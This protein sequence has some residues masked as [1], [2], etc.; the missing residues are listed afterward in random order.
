MEKIRKIF[1]ITCIFLAVIAAGLFTSGFVK[2]TTIKQEIVSQLNEYLK[3]EISVEDIQFQMLQSFPYATISFQNVSTKGV[4]PEAREKLMNAEEVSVLFDIMELIKGN[5]TLKKIKIKNAFLNILVLPDGTAN[6]NIISVDKKA[7]SSNFKIDLKNVEFSNVSI[8]YVH[9]PSNQEYLFRINKGQL[10]GLFSSENQ[11]LDFDG[12]IFS[13]HIKSGSKIF[14]E[15][16]ELTID[17][18]L[19]LNNLEKH[20]TIHEGNVKTNGLHFSFSGNIKT[21]Q[22]KP[23]LDL[24][25][26]TEKT[27][28][29]V[30]FKNIPKEF[31]Q[32]L[33]DFQLNG[34]IKL[35]SQII[36]TFSGNQVPRINVEFDV[37]NGAFKHDLKNLHFRNIDFSGNFDNGNKHQ[38]QTYKL[39][40]KDAKIALDG[41]YLAGNLNIQNFEK[42]NI[43][44]DFT[45]SI[46]LE[47]LKNYFIIDTVKNL[48]GL[49]EIN[50]SFQ[51][52]LKDFRQFTIHDFIS[53]K[54][55]GEM[56]IKNMHL[57]LKNSPHKFTDFNG[58]FKF[59]NKDL[60]VKQFSGNVSETDFILKGTFRNILAYAFSNNEPVFI[61]ADLIS[62]HF[63]L[64]RLL[65]K[66]N[67]KTS[68]KGLQFSNRIN[69]KLN[70]DLDEFNFRKFSA[71]SITGTINQQNKILSVSN[72]KFSSMDGKARI[73]GTINGRNPVNHLIS[74]KAEINN[75]NIQK[76]F[77][78]LGNF[79]Q[80]NLT[81]DHIRG[82]VDATLEYSSTL[83]PSLKVD[84]GS[85][86]SLGDISI[87]NGELINYP[88]LQ[89]LSKYIKEEELKHV[90]FSK[91]TNQVKIENKVV[92]LP[93]MDIESSS[94]NIHL[95]GNHNF[96]NTI[97]YH[98]QLLVSEIFL[99]KNIKESDIGSDFIKDDG[100][101]RTK[102][103][104]RLTGNAK[105]PNVK[106]DTPEV[107]DKIATDLKKEKETLKKV[108][109][110]EFK[111][112]ST[113][114]N[115]EEAL[116]IESENQKDFIIEFEEPTLDSIPS[117]PQKKDKEKSQKKKN[118][119]KDFIII[120]DEE[121]DTI[122]I[123]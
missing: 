62:K 60:E 116:L 16:T 109:Q 118:S 58:S 72:V 77:H 86:Y 44:V 100:L 104:I 105:D 43:R 87:S 61:S 24:K 80:E 112:K 26:Q 29:S 30:L 79:G 38:K 71:S 48:S 63:N 3:V 56:K 33:K 94:L 85:V 54:T 21:A 25:V 18:L 74:C 110:E 27:E 46:Q 73:W 22:N 97:D 39:V 45:S 2:S 34:E 19:A 32:P 20:L 96:D 123:N 103:F 51:N 101:G 13:T 31:L 113:E 69:Y 57:A 70:I 108:L 117:K 89:K 106:Y 98:L 91:L 50:M 93:D 28:L 82:T 49:L 111:I 122:K 11:Q 53:S 23:V 7:N 65:P 17:V 99:N 76:L 42:P 64:D 88:P 121:N 10:K 47:N 81:D 67:E 66:S 12:D 83:S 107:R 14:L 5:Y 15:N 40:L 75:V 35:K 55:S 37:L 84:A 120:W 115:T 6:Y 36:G 41:G 114:E 78:D 4:D 90:R 9:Y 119:E 95:F 59:N 102:L 8:S 92:Y 1:I 68:A 52:K